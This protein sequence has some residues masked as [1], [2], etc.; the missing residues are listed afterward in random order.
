MG[1][2]KFGK[3]L[4]KKALRAFTQKNLEKGAVECIIF[5]TYYERMA[6]LMHIPVHVSRNP[7]QN[8]TK[9]IR[10]FS[11]LLYRLIVQVCNYQYGTVLKYCKLQNVPNT[12]NIGP[13]VLYNRIGTCTRI[14]LVLNTPF[15]FQRIVFSSYSKRM[16]AM[17]YVLVHVLQNPRQN[18]TKITQRFS[19]FC[20]A[21]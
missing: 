1:K 12:V 15:K 3:V 4:N 11:F 19:F 16:A 8:S 7:R 20:T 10:R 5:S 13:T 9:T 2:P 18:S 21:Q 17:T 14:S 6:S